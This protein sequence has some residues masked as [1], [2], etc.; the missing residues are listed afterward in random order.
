MNEKHLSDI[1]LTN[2]T[3]RTFTP[4]PTAWEDQV[5]Y[6][7]MVD[8]FHDDRQGR[9]AVF[10]LRDETCQREAIAAQHAL[11]QRERIAGHL[12]TLARRESVPALP[13]GSSYCARTKVRS[14][15]SW[16]SFATLS[17]SSCGTWI[18]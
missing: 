10:D 14:V 5:L 13:V 15:S 4:S 18:P 6:F 8:R 3:N 1:N 16:M 7:L 11:H 12:K 2:L 17:M 9:G